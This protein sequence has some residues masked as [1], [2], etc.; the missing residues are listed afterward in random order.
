MDLPDEIIEQH[1]LGFALIGFLRQIFDR[2][3]NGPLGKEWT[4]VTR[5]GIALYLEKP[6]TNMSGW[7]SIQTSE[8][9]GEVLQSGSITFRSLV[10]PSNLAESFL[11]REEKDNVQFRLTPKCAKF[12]EPVRVMAVSRHEHEK[13]ERIDGRAQRIVEHF[14]SLLSGK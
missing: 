7:I 1:E 9:W 14:G 11:E 4:I 10:M 6:A 2:S 5:L 3:V 8:G 13:Q 12:L